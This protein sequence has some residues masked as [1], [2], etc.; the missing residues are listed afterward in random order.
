[1]H[2][3]IHNQELCENN[4]L[5]MSCLSKWHTK[6][7]T[8]FKNLKDKIRKSR[9]TNIS[10]M[11]EHLEEALVR[12]TLLSWRVTP[13]VG[14]PPPGSSHALSMGISSYDLVLRHPL[15]FC[16]KYLTLAAEPSLYKRLPWASLHFTPKPSSLPHKALIPSTP[17]W[18]MVDKTLVLYISSSSTYNLEGIPHAINP[19]LE[20]TF[21]G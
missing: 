3:F 11:D 1:M 10:C 21:M 13:G 17:S 15:G 20:D 12:A 8:I 7:P 9:D 14:R 16:A 19:V 5:L 2:F 4:T 6:L 18:A